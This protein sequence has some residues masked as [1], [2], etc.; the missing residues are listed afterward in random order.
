MV[1][2]WDRFW[3]CCNAMC[4]Y[5]WNLSSFLSYPPISF[6]FERSSISDRRISLKKIVENN[7][8]RLLF[9][10][11]ILRPTDSISRANFTSRINGTQEEG[12]Q[13]KLVLFRLDQRGNSSQRSVEDCP[14]EPS[15]KC[16][17]KDP[18]NKS[19]RLSKSWKK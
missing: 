10:K 18:V 2:A 11:I 14:V 16:L 12:A 1:E 15:K 7:K 9:S 4:S 6:I 3:R 13:K 5:Q 17:G 19:M 8:L